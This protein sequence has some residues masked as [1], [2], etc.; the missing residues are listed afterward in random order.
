[1]EVDAMKPG[2]RTSEFWITTGLSVLNVSL[3]VLGQVSPETAV[4]VNGV[5]GGV[6]T[7]LRTLAKGGVIRGTIGEELRRD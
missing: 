4:I 1:V 2:V 7:I 3:S 6:Y 5:M